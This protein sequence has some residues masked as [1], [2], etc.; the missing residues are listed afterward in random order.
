MCHPFVFSY[1]K[2]G[3]RGVVFH[4]VVVVI[5]YVI[6]LS[7]SLFKNLF[8]VFYLVSPASLFSRTDYATCV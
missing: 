8:G 3:G 7:V 1:V 6:Q 4:S 5:Y 2:R